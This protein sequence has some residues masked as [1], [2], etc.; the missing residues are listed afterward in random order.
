MTDV[1]RFV[2]ANWPTA[3]ALAAILFFT[4]F[5]L[6]FPRVSSPQDWRRRVPVI[7]ALG[8]L[9]LAAGFMVP[10][11]AQAPYV[12]AIVGLKLFSIAKL[13][14]PGEVIFIGSLLL[15]D[16]LTY[17]F[18]WLSHKIPLLWRLHAVHH[19]DEHV[20][21][22]SGQLHHPFEV[23][24]QYFT[25]MFAYVVFGVPIV[26]VAAYAVLAGV[27]NA[28]AHADIALPERLERWL[29]LVIVTPDMH[30]VHHSVERREGNSNFSQVFSVWDRLFRTYIPEPSRPPRE[31]RMGLSPDWAPRA[32]S[33]PALLLLPFR[34]RAR[35]KER[36]AEGRPS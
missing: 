36:A 13:P 25:L 16:F 11:V 26:A 28:F 15:V 9:S 8:L 3:L 4:P 21:A 12:K 34:T 1:W 7:A 35:Q 6:L 30:R 27:H 24:A 20:T 17:A 31:L 14:L 29:R 18:H 22:L 23:I 5:E 19:A 32:F 33:L 2:A 10:L